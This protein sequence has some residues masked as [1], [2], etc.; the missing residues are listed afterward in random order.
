MSWL[1]KNAS[2][3]RE[4]RAGCNEKEIGP[5][6]SGRSPS[7]LGC[8][9]EALL[10]R[11]A[12]PTKAVGLATAWAMLRGLHAPTGQNSGF[13]R[14]A[15]SPERTKDNGPTSLVNS[16]AIVRSD[17]CGIEAGRV[18]CTDGL[19][20]GPS[21]LLPSRMEPRP[22]AWANDFGTFGAS[23]VDQKLQSSNLP[24][25]PA[26]GQSPVLRLRPRLK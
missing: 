10:A 25:R 20:F 7:G 5:E 23:G 19:T 21:G 9:Q 8:G 12:I 4:K 24:P 26:N 17:R 1:T 11:V 3:V 16:R 2:T 18:A 22:L 15:G 13:E 6:G 14:E